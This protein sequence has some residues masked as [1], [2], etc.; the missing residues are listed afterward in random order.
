M[1]GF[2][3]IQHKISVILKEIN[4]GNDTSEG[5]SEELVKLGYRKHK[6]NPASIRMFIYNRM[7]KQ[8]VEAVYSE[9]RGVR[10]I[11]GYRAI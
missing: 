3:N 11:E 1:T 7:D 6:V 10:K 9:Y 4:S 8:Y 2:K 5:I